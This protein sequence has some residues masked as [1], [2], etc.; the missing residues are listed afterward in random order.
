MNKARGKVYGWHFSLPCVARVF[1]DRR[2]RGDAPFAEQC[3]S[4]AIRL[5]ENIESNAWDGALYRRA[6]FDN[7]EPLGSATNTECQIDSIPQS[8][9]ILSGAGEPSRSRRAMEAVSGRLV[10]RDQSLIQL[11]DPPFDKSAQDPGYIKGYV[12]GVRENGGQYTH[13]AIWTVMAFAA[14]GD[15]GSGPGNCWP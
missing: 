5:Q 6:Y 4:A 13:G 3:V 9:S 2:L 8:W 14:L 7:G 15:S 11:F 1:R 10:R 12:P